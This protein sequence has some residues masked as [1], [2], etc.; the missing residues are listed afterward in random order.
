MKKIESIIVGQ[1]PGTSSYLKKY[2]V[3]KFPEISILGEAANHKQACELIKNTNPDLVFS[4]VSVFHKH[5]AAIGEEGQDKRYEVIYISDHSEDAV[6]AIRHDACGFILKPL[7]AND[8]AVSVSSAIRRLSE[9]L[10]PFGSHQS[11]SPDTSVLPHT[12][13]VGI[14]TMEGIEFLYTQEIVRCEGLQ[15]CTRIVCMRKH[16]LISSYN[17]GEFKKLLEEYGFFS[18]HKSH[19]INLM[20][21]R[22]LAREGFIT[23]TDNTPIPLARRKRLEFLH[24][25]KHV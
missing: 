12:K 11:Y 9:R 2:L 10:L 13:L 15:K 7:N 5:S 3:D 20:H 17:I 21:V 8:I 1:T 4:D 22:K 16:N 23:L 19:L 6:L 18:C 25:L 24:L 14:P